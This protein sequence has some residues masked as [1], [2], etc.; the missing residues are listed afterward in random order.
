MIWCCVTTARVLGSI[1]VVQALV[2]SKI[3]PKC[4]GVL[5]AK[6]VVLSNFEN[7]LLSVHCNT[8]YFF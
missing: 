5:C 1:L 6:N 2:W 3:F 4:G 8:C 7:R